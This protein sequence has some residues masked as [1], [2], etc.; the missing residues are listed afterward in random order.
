MFPANTKF[1]IA[2]D[3][4]TMRKVVKRVYQKHFPSQ[5]A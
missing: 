1:L 5:A 3:F 2:D 4:A